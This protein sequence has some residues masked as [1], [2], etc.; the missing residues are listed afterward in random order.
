LEVLGT[1]AG[2]AIFL[3]LLLG[4]FMPCRGEPRLAFGGIRAGYYERPPGRKKDKG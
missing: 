3:P 2:D 1:F 4:P